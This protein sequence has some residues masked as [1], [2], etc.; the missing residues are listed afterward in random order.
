M[1]QLDVNSNVQTYMLNWSLL[2]VKHSLYR[3]WGFQEVE[4]PRFPDNQHMKVVRLSAL[5]TGDPYPP[6]N[7]P[8]TNFF[9][10]FS[11]PQDQSVAKRIL[12]LLLILQSFDWLASFQLELLQA[13]PFIAV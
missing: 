8:G 4:G 7:I 9:Q 10:G 1:T 5:C 2:Q 3:P 11:Q 6:G 13:I 12:L